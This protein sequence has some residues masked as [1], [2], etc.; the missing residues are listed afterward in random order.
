M[1]SSQVIDWKRHQFLSSLSTWI[2][3]TH[4]AVGSLSLEFSWLS[5]LLSS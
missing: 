3:A 4:S 2:D 5:I 1:V